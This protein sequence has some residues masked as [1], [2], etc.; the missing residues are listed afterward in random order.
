MRI[1]CFAFLASFT[2]SVHA[3]EF[4]PNLNSIGEE[5][6]YGPYPIMSDSNSKPATSSLVSAS[7]PRSAAMTRDS[8]YIIFEANRNELVSDGVEREWFIKNT[9]TYELE[10]IGRPSSLDPKVHMNKATIS[11]NGRYIGFTYYVS[12]VWRSVVWDRLT[13]EMKAAEYDENHQPIETAN[14][15]PRTPYQINDRLVILSDY[16]GKFSITDLTDKTTKI[17]NIDIYGNEATNWLSYLR[18][19]SDDGRYVVYK[20]S[21]DQMDAE[22]I[23]EDP[24]K[25][26]ALYIYDSVKDKHTKISHSRKENHAFAGSNQY[27]FSISADGKHVI[28]TARRPSEPEYSHYEEFTSYLVVYNI[29]AQTYEYVT[30]VN[31]KLIQNIATPSISNDAENIAFTTRNDDYLSVGSNSNYQVVYFDRVNNK[32]I[33]PSISQVTGAPTSQTVHP[34]VYGNGNGVFWTGYGAPLLEG[35]T[36]GMHYYIIGEPA[37]PIIPEICLPYIN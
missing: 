1:L 21:R 36:S 37:E 6:E 11:P 23:S 31:G 32:M 27:A 8:K 22:N 2:L 9:E 25:E 4:D 28:Y 3:V 13:G 29:S 5:P 14:T 15:A 18:P 26:T 35:E 7:R 20:T 16:M 17:M 30:D 34:V 24:S 12:S 10:K 19:F 33:Q